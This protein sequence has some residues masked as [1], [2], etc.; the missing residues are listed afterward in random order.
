MALFGSGIDKAAA[1][2]RGLHEQRQ[3]LAGRAAALQA[4]LRELQARD[5]DAILAELLQDDSAEVGK[6][7]LTIVALEGQLQDLDIGQAA[8]VRKLHVAIGAWASARA[9]VPRES[10]GRLRTQF[11]DHEKETLRLL[12]LLAKHEGRFTLTGPPPA[13]VGKGVVAGPI[14]VQIPKSTQIAQQ[15]RRLEDEANAIEAAPKNRAAKGHQVEGGDLEAILKACSDP[16]LVAPLE[17]YIRAWYSETSSRPAANYYRH[18][19]EYYGPQVPAGRRNY[20]L[21][22]DSNS[23][24]DNSASMSVRIDEAP[25][26]LEPQAAA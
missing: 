2:V 5:G 14:A 9:T 21:H 16:E 8:L 22:W 1:T 18:D 25:V 10:A 7:R 13:P 20:V 4:R 24:I 3:K 26:R 17:A 19:E 12:D 15:I 11:A 6:T 23:Q